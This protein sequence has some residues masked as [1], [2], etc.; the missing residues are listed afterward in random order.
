M[1]CTLCNRITRWM[2]E[3]QDWGKSS[4]CLGRDLEWLTSAETDEDG[5]ATAARLFAAIHEVLQA[6]SIISITKRRFLTR[7]RT[8]APIAKPARSSHR[9]RRRKKG[10]GGGLR[11]CIAARESHPLLNR[12]RPSA[13]RKTPATPELFTGGHPAARGAQQH[14]GAALWALPCLRRYGRR[15]NVLS[16]CDPC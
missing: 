15:S 10:A 2:R 6:P 13:M 3:V 1:M 4:S 8:G 9:P 11:T 5:S 12:E 16:L 14:R 7:T